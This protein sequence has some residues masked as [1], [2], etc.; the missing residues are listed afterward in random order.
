LTLLASKLDYGVL[1]TAK[2]VSQKINP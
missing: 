2:I 1:E